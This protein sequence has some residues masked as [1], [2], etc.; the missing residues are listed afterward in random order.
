MNPNGLKIQQLYLLKKSDYTIK[1][2]KMFEEL[3][4]SALALTVDTQAF[5]KR[6]IDERN[7]FLPVV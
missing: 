6:R 2:L 7:K 3:G 5:G 1:F 4:Y